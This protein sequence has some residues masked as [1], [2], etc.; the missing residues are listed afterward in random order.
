MAGDV[1]GS[2]R[3]GG[4]DRERERERQTNTEGETGIDTHMG[5][6]LAGK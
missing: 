6:A 4:R 2:E 3:E 1:V 5:G